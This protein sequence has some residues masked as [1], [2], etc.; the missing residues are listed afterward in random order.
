MQLILTLL[1][2]LMQAQGLQVRVSQGLTHFP[3]NL[4]G[5]ITD[6]GMG[7]IPALIGEAS[8]TNLKVISRTNGASSI[9]LRVRD[10]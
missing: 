8:S 3:G 4:V 5:G 1:H 7:C 2:L 6:T 9:G 10:Y